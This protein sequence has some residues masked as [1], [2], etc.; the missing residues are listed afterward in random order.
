[1]SEQDYE[2]N[3]GPVATER[4]H[5]EPAETERAAETDEGVAAGGEAEAVEGA[6]GAQHADNV[7]EADDPYATHTT[8][9]E[10]DGVDDP[11]AAHATATSEADGVEDPYVTD[12]TTSEADDVDDPYATHATA[13]ATSEAD[14]A[15]D[16]YE[17]HATTGAD[18]PAAV[19]PYAEPPA[20]PY[21]EPLPGAADLSMTGY[22]PP[23]PDPAASQP[24][25]DLVAVPTTGTD[26]FARMQEIQVAFIDDPRQAAL[27]AEELL[28]DV[29]HSFTEELTRQ[30]EAL[31]SSS[32]DGAPDTER[33]RLAVRRSRQLIDALVSLD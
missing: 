28:S 3:H 31:Q 14:D 4:P 29:L 5:D 27:D 17:T 9:S 10:A 21:A 11:Y 30:R 15:D 22:L 24:E 20:D 19:D 33:M 18:E 32:D 6:N 26:H 2:S 23:V 12:T 1:M 16:P 8:T 25:A 7:D 13:T